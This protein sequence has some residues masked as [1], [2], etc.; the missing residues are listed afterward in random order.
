[1][2]E[3]VTCSLLNFLLGCDIFTPVSVCTIGRITVGL[4]SVHRSSGL[5]TSL[6]GSSDSLGDETNCFHF[7]PGVLHQ[8]GVS[9]TFLT[10]GS[11]IENIAEDATCL[12]VYT[13]LPLELTVYRR[14]SF[15][16]WLN[17]NTMQQESSS[18]L[19]EFLQ[20]QL[21]SNSST[22]N[23]HALL[24]CGSVILPDL[25]PFKEENE[26]KEMIERFAITRPTARI[27]VNRHSS[28]SL[29]SATRASD[30]LADEAE[31]RTSQQQGQGLEQQTIQSSAASSAATAAATPASPS[32]STSIL[33]TP[34]P[35]SNVFDPLLLISGSSGVSSS[36]VSRSMGDGKFKLGVGSISS[37][38]SS[39][40]I[41]SDYDLLNRVSH[42]SR[43]SNLY[44]GALTEYAIV[45]SIT[46]YAIYQLD[47]SG[48]I[49]SWNE[50]AAR[51][52]G[53]S[54]AEA[55]GQHF[56][57][58]YTPDD[59]QSNRP[60]MELQVASREGRFESQGWRV[61]KDNSRFWANLILTRIQNQAGEI[62]GF[63]KITRDETAKKAAQD[64]LLKQQELLIES[65][66]RQRLLIDSVMDYA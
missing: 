38:L 23:F 59:I 66:E 56:S 33:L 55:I 44:R 2:Y 9:S 10:R 24:L 58:F 65:E 46:D 61:R 52:K 28:L 4:D 47:T 62:I 48:C 8:F 16:E 26:A 3:S 1:M 45:N 64:K 53:Y 39:S 7:L 35:S 37:S 20:R 63:A 43:S 36:L 57:L 11:V 51:L 27:R 29:P 25:T 32:V 50:G 6:Y 60:Q 19:Y 13:L 34:T 42:F 49:R 30:A 54:S 15:E 12:V 31:K 18:V 17:L 5:I 40:T 41:R 14:V 21:L 22:S